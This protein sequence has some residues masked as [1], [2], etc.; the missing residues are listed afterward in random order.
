[1]KRSVKWFMSLGL[2]GAF[3]VAGISNVNAE[4]RHP[5]PK[6]KTLGNL[7]LPVLADLTQTLFLEFLLG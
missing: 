1:M 3:V 5:H 7:E 6:Y 4:T 2:V